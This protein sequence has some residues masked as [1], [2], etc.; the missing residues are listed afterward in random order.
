[1]TVAKAVGVTGIFA[2]RCA[3]MKS[4]SSAMVMPP[5]APLPGRR[6][7]LHLAATAALAAP[8]HAS[9]A[10][11]RRFTIGFA[12]LTHDPGAPIEAPGSTGAPLLSPF[13]PAPPLP[14]L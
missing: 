11:P 12:N 8:S 13:S 9:V 14:P 1:M 10:Q 3:S 5:T 4:H 7:F 2:H 6:A